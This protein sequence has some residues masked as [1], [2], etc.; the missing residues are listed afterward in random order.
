MREVIR[1]ERDGKMLRILYFKLHYFTQCREGI[2][3]CLNSVFWILVGVFYCFIEKREV[4]E[5]ITFAV[6]S[7]SLIDE[8]L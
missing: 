1:V 4:R 5:S 7:E 8:G 2:G 6:L 3:T